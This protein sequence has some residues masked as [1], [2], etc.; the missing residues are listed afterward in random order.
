[1]TD[2][3]RHARA[4]AVSRAPVVVAVRRRATLPRREHPRQPATGRWSAGDRQSPS[5]SVATRGPVAGW[6]GCPLRGS[7]SPRPPAQGAPG[8]TATRARDEGARG[9]AHRV[10]RPTQPG[11]V[12]WP[13]AG[14]PGAAWDGTL[15]EPAVVH[16]DG[17]GVRSRAAPGARHRAVD[18]P[19]RADSRVPT[20]AADKATAVPAAPGTPPEDPAVRARV[21]AAALPPD[22]AEAVLPRAVVELGRPVQTSALPELRRLAEQLALPPGACGTD[23]VDRG[24]LHCDDDTEV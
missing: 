14:D 12:R 9:T 16:G 13:G 8:R 15:C 3:R 24:G 11:H 22:P 19:R 7:S 4:E 20:A 6:C 21:A 5:G 1:M 2:G 17:A 18:H 23:A 10:V